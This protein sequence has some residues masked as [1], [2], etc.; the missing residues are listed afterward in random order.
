MPNDHEHKEG[1]SK[2][3]NN[4]RKSLIQKSVEY[5]KVCKDDFMSWNN[6]TN[7]D[8]QELQTVQT[9]MRIMLLAIFIMIGIVIYMILN[10]QFQKYD[11]SICRVKTFK[12][13]KDPLPFG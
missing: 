6:K 12:M 4:G 7:G 2:D 11:D 8:N 5:F 9:T 3:D 1:N 10:A 13:I